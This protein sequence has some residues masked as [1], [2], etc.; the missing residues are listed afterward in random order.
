MTRIPALA[1]PW[2]GGEVGETVTPAA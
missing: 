1:R 2:V